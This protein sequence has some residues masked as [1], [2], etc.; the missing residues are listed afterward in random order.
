M[1]LPKYLTLTAI[2]SLTSWGAFSATG[3]DSLRTE[4]IG[5]QN[6]VIHE[7]EAKET[8]FAIS[9]RYKTP[10][11][12]IV[13]ANE[14]LK[15]GL[16]VG[17]QI[18][19]P[20][21]SEAA[22][23]EGS[24]LHKVASGETLFAISKKYGVSV[25][26][27]KQWNNL[28][29][30]DLSVGQALVIRKTVSEPSPLAE[31]KEPTPSTAPVK[32][33]PKKE[34]TS[35]PVAIAETPKEEVKKIEKVVEEKPKSEPKAT[36][37]APSNATPIVPGDWISHEVR[38]GETL[39][40]I[41][42]Q[43]NAPIED[44]I[45]WNALSSNNLKVGQVLKVGRAEPGPSKVPIVGDPKVATSMEEMH[46]VPDGASTGG[47]KNISEMGQAEVIP[48]T[49][50]HKKY[51]VLHRTA[52]VGTIMRVRNEENDITIFAR[53]VGALPETGD[54]SKLVIKLSQ[55]AYEQLKA[56]NSRFPVE[57][58]Y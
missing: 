54:N 57:V 29:G 34:V 3:L 24:D 17:Q 52:P 28:K 35:K 1:H 58:T 13:K 51:L 23:P 21:I 5:G 6:F 36:V 40:S 46:Q 30:N 49:G 20:Y 41:A 39:F 33:S 11:G 7:V 37:S 47:F 45:T 56:V 27:L 10:V 9:R 18:R 19:V 42:N 22:I 38:S 16:Q 14:S 43:Y 55:A 4:K 53:V 15:S 25:D 12:D 44:L 2:L 31:V 48:G 32:E 8:L 26:E 50:G